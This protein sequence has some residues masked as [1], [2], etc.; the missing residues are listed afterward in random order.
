MVRD[1]RTALRPAAKPELI[2]RR[3]AMIALSAKYGA[4][5]FAWARG[6]TCVHAARFLLRQMGHRP[7]PLPQIRSLIGARRALAVRGWADTAAMLDAPRCAGG[8]GLARIAPAAMLVA[9]LAV[10]PSADGL[11]AIFFYAGGRKFMGWRED[12]IG[13]ALVEVGFA[14][15]TAAWRV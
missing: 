10:V 15:L 7:P 11:G 2:R 6:R 14:E 5:E 3:D 8:A 4:R 12:A 1:Q 13:L 9:D